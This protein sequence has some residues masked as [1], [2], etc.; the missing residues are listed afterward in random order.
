MEKI[1]FISTVRNEE[2]SIQVFL[3]SLLAQIQLPDEVII[4]DADSTDRTYE[5]LLSHTKFFEKKKIAYHVIQKKCNRGQ[6]RNL[7]IEKAAHPIIVASD[8]GCTLQK[9]WLEKITTP[10]QDPSIDVVSGYYRPAP[11][12]IYQKCVATYTCVMPDK[13]TEDF[14]PSSRSV[15][16]RKT[17]W[18]KVGGY[19]EQYETFEDL[20]FSLLLKDSGM[21]MVVASEAIVIWPQRET[22]K[23]VAYQLFVY[24]RGDGQAKYIRP[25]TPLLFGR[26]ALGFL[27]YVGGFYDN[28][29][30]IVL[31]TLF[32]LYLVWSIA[33]NYRYVGHYKA[34]IFLPLLQLIAD[35]AVIA[36]MIIGS[37][38]RVT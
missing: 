20:G 4:V 30:W 37:I 13:L 10:F 19:P 18:K 34:F 27:L 32:M 1:T 11:G 36:G 25:Q 33:K 28:R 9:D 23:E 15:A 31:T 5:I 6:G 22:L 24:A 35:I 17:A 7:A 14:L 8:V 2:T 38:D 3:K 21:N 16:F 29:L 12:T 26:Y